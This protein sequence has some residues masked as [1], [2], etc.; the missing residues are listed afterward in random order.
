[1]ED[2]RSQKRVRFEEDPPSPQDSPRRLPYIRATYVKEGAS[3][4]V[5]YTVH[6]RWVSDELMQV[7][8][9]LTDETNTCYI[10]NC[11]SRTFKDIF[12]NEV[13]SLFK[14]HD[15]TATLTDADTILATPVIKLVDGHE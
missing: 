3:C 9:S 2:Q 6:M 13:F 7:I 1:M 10:I 11:D 4:A 14:S 15:C 8:R 5:C 12:A